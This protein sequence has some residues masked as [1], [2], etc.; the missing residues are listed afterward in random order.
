V[1]GTGTPPTVN[2][3]G[4]TAIIDLSGTTPRTHTF[5]VIPAGSPTGCTYHVEG[6]LDKT[7]WTNLSGSITCTTTA[8]TFVVDKPVIYI[9]GWVDTLTG[10]T[11]PT[12]TLQYLGDR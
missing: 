6:S 7:T 9:R 10:G 8:F 11:N 12:A 2:S 1:A 3:T 5:V 4:A